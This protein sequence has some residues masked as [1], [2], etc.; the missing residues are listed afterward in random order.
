[1]M[2]I[3]V[4]VIIIIII[5][6]VIII[7]IIITITTLI[8]SKCTGGT[9]AA[10]HLPLASWPSK[11]GFPKSFPAKIPR[12]LIYKSF[13]KSFP[14]KIPTNFPKSVPTKIPRCLIFDAGSWE[15]KRTAVQPWQSPRGRTGRPRQI[16]KYELSNHNNFN[17]RFWSCPAFSSPLRRAGA[18]SGEEKARHSHAGACVTI[19]AQRALAAIASKWRLY[20]ISRLVPE[21]VLKI[22]R[23]SEAYAYRNTCQNLRTSA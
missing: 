13:P 15:G 6:I 23:A 2:L 10:L 11:A 5:V 21:S 7:I 20:G 18:L 3:V 16:S 17:I 8:I 4:I 9:L 22:A 19:R 12:C 14:T 1:M